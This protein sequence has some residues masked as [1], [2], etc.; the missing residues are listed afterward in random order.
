VALAERHIGHLQPFERWFPLCDLDER[1]ALLVAFVVHG[2]LVLIV[3]ANDAERGDRAGGRLSESLR[4][5]CQAQGQGGCGSQ[6]IDA[7]AGSSIV[8]R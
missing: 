5:G 2:Q 3:R 7:H 4:G 8:I 6:T 1:E